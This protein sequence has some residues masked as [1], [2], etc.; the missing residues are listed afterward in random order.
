MEETLEEYM[1]GDMEDDDT[2]DDDSS[3]ADP[4][5]IYSDPRNFFS[6]LPHLPQPS[7]Y[8]SASEVRREARE[9]SQKILA[10]WS[11]LN[12]VVERHEAVLR[13]RWS[14]KTQE[15][16]RRILLT[17]WPN[18]A[19][20]HRPDFE[21]FT[22]ESQEERSRGTR[23]RDAFMWPYINLEDLLK[24]KHLLLFLNARGRHHPGAF[25]GADYEAARFGFITCALRPAF[26]NHHTMMFT[27]RTTP[28][29]YG[30]L[31]AWED[32]DEACDWMQTGAGMH[33]GQGLQL[34]ETQQRIWSFLVDCCLQILHDMPPKSLMLAEA[35][36]QPEPPPVSGQEAG[37]HSLAVVAAEAPYRIPA[38]LD[39][40]RLIAMI[41]SKRSAAEDHIWALREDPGYFADVVGDW[42][43]H[44]Q[45]MLPDTNGR[46][47]PT[48]KLL[49]S[50]TFWDWVL[51]NVVV[52]AYLQIEI[53]TSIHQQ[54]VNLQTLK[55]KY[56]VDT[57]AGK[58]LPEEY[59]EALHLLLYS[60][61]RFSA[62]PIDSLKVG[63]P[64]SPPLRS[65]FVR[66]PQEPGTPMIRVIERRN[67]DKDKH[68]GR[69]LWILTTL[70]DEQ[71]RFLAGLQPLMDELERLL[72]NDPTQKRLIS[73]WVASIIADLSVISGCLHQLDRSHSTEKTV[74]HT[75]ALIDEDHK[76]EYDRTMS[77]F[78]EFVKA[79]EGAPLA[80]LG[81][82]SEGRFFYPVDKRRTKENVDAM[83]RAEAHLDAFWQSVDRHLIKRAGKSEHTGLLRLLPEDR[84]LQRTPEWVEPARG[85]KIGS[86]SEGPDAL[87]KPLA[88]IDLNDL[89]RRTEST[90]EREESA[91]AKI[92]TKT[93]GSVEPSPA[94]VGSAP[95]PSDG[96]HEPDR[97]FTVD[98]RALRVFA[99]IFHTPSKAV[100]PGEVAWTDFVHALASTGFAAEKLYGS[101]WHFTPPPDRDVEWR[102]IQF[103]EPHPGGKIPFRT[104][105]RHGRRLNR[106][107]GWHAGMFE[108]A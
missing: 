81:T 28:E 105:R 61:K 15:K 78:G 84:V 34:L 16:R 36:V 51:G 44:R 47:H 8:P 40:A 86:E 94:T 88:L 77:R 10:D 89:T 66:E 85:P 32:H 26:L 18:M 13:R 96:H 39:L 108:A 64:A 21:A 93:R 87:T 52:D 6:Q 58:A 29:T 106:T 35:P 75:E 72:Q 33:P 25:V 95:K 76:P 54:L 9:R 65:H 31:I 1:G 3:M 5:S 41:E 7:S 100:Q 103:H 98:K 23:F 82:P 57:A 107:Y 67:R 70:W 74:P 62:R 4:H 69:L 73:S 30:E 12:K 43:E 83:R 101:V 2:E 38:A 20:T 71:K 63:V 19:P 14:Q 99:T 53:W 60:L 27:G 97:R 24:P 42:K 79:F 102:S 55:D 22:K 104:A 17:A 11:F 80:A 92:K 91:S 50:H 59:L 90:L 56:S 37:W 48:L 46:Q 68:F 49:S 45:E